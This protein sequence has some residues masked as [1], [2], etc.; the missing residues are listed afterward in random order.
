MFNASKVARTLLLGVALATASGISTAAKPENPCAD[1]NDC[2][3]Y[4]T[5][6]SCWYAMFGCYCEYDV[7]HRCLPTP[8]SRDEPGPSV[9]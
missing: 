6:T 1:Y 3:P 5:G 2:F 4:G 8:I 9:W 7:L